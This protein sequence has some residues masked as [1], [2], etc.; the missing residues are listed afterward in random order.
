MSETQGLDYELV[1]QFA[2]AFINQRRTESTRR[3][4]VKTGGISP[5]LSG[6]ERTAGSFGWS[7]GHGA[8]KLFFEHQW[9][10]R[11]FGTRAARLTEAG[12]AGKREWDVQVD[13]LTLP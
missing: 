10:K 6:L 5:A 2:L 9:L 11:V 3:S 8:D 12:R 13:K 4:F 7:T 1:R